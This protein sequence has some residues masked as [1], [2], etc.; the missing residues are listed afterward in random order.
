MCPLLG[1]ALRVA[2]VDEVAVDV[3]VAQVQ[4]RLGVFD[5][6]GGQCSVGQCP[7]GGGAEQG[8]GQGLADFHYCCAPSSEAAACQA[9]ASGRLQG[10]WGEWPVVDQGETRESGAQVP[11]A[12]SDSPQRRMLERG[13]CE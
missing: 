3:E 2:R 6:A 7:Q 13:G 1:L 5:E 12:A 11:V 10:R 8:E 4:G 9:R